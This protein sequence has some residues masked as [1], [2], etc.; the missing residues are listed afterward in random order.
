[1]NDMISKL[2]G[3][4]TPEQD[5]SDAKLQVLN[6][7]RDMMM[8]LMGDKVKGKMSPVNEVSISA[9]DSKGLAKGLDIA[10]DVLPS[11][12]HSAAAPTDS[13][14]IGEQ[15]DMDDDMSLEEIDAMMKELE[16][17]RREKMMKA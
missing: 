3:A 11:A 1:M 14:E 13:E 2:T 9:P 10:K 17:K 12:D 7:L 8:G 4:N 15:S 5:P 16:A 6:E